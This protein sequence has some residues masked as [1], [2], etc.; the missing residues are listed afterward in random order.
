M[1]L[2]EY[3]NELLWHFLSLDR[4]SPSNMAKRALISRISAK[5]DSETL[6]VQGSSSANEDE[7]EAVSVPLTDSVVEL[8][9][10]ATEAIIKVVLFI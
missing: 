10:D 1:D 4:Y 8:E 7:E 9:V 5:N 6:L 3:T 2:V